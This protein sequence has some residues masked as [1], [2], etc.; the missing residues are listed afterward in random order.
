M[1]LGENTGIVK[2]N[3]THKFRSVANLVES[4]RPGITLGKIDENFVRDYRRHL[5]QKGSIDAT[6]AKEY[7]FLRIAAEWAGIAP[8]QPWLRYSEQSAPQVDLEK[9]ELCRLIRTPMPTPQLELERDRWLLECFAGRPDADMAGLLNK[10]LEYLDTQ[11]LTNWALC[12][13][14]TWLMVICNSEPVLSSICRKHKAA[15]SG[16]T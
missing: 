2:E 16:L 6:I 12:G 4:F 14:A 3:Y 7:K 11:R 15:F 5:L 8:S 13:C 10:Q 9:E 1:W